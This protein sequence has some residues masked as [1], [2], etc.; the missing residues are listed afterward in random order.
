MEKHTKKD[1]IG[2]IHT[3]CQRQMERFLLIEPITKNENVVVISAEGYEDL[4]VILDQKGNLVEKAPE[5][6]EE[7]PAP[8]VGDT[9]YFFGSYTITVGMGNDDWMKAITGVTV[10]GE[11]YEKGY[12]RDNTY[13][14][15]T[16]RD[17]KISLDKAGFTENEN[18]VVISAEWLWMQ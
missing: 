12:Y 10:N 18:V 11:A 2:I 16:T 13:S 1:I 4:E 9:D 3:R 14:L 15:A 5:E 6:S 17:G 7:K 8:L